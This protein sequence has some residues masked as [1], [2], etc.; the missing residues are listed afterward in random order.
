M[1]SGSQ[2]KTIEVD[3]GLFL[4]RYASAAD[5]AQ[6]PRVN[7][8][9]DAA[10]KRSISLLIHPDEKEASLWRPGACFVVC[11]TA[12]GTL[13]VEVEPG[14]HCTSAAASVQ[15]EP[16]SQ[17]GPIAKGG[18][19][20]M[21]Q[22][23]RESSRPFD[24]EITLVGHVAGLGDVR[25]NP[26]EWLAGPRA[27]A[28]IEGL[29]IEWADRPADLTIRYSVATAKPNAASQ[30]ITELGG[31]AGTRGKAL[32]LIGVTFELF[33]PAAAQAQLNVEAI[34]LGS[35]A[36]QD[37]GPRVVLA[38]PTGREPLVGLKISVERISAHAP[39]P[40]SP[41]ANDFEN[42]SKGIRVFRSRAKPNQSAT[43]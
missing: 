18:P 8:A 30:R 15:I 38:G 3:R 12:P 26:G 36:L 40:L 1:A 25:V 11:A 13:I 39:G 37:I 16:L 17:G 21:G 29:S 19:T 6:P 23:T 24:L 14:P 5:E 27:P 43:L 22:V 9:P 41:A 7:V 33:G 20:S 2:R 28:R 10:S 31:Y 32:A 34:F 35:P 42:P 4:I